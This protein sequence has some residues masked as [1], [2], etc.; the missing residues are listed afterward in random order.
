MPLKHINISFCRWLFCALL[1]FCAISEGQAAIDKREF[2]IQLK[3]GQ[4]CLDRHRYAD[5]YNIFHKLAG[6]YKSNL[7]TEDKLLSLEAIYGCIE[8]SID[9]VN[10][11]DA[12][13]YLMLAEEIRESENISD[14]RLHLFY[15]DLYIVYGA[16]SNKRSVFKYAY[17]HGKGAFD[18]F[19]E[20]GDWTRAEKAFGNLINIWYMLEK[21]PEQNK[22]LS[23]AKETFEKKVPDR[24]QKLNKLYFLEARQMEL[25]NNPKAASA[26]YDTIL[27]VIPDVPDNAILRAHMRC[28]AAIAR[29]NSGRTAEAMVALDSAI[30]ATIRW[31]IPNLQELAL[32][33]YSLILK[34]LGDS[35]KAADYMSRALE[36]K[37]SIRSFAVADDLFGLENMHQQKELRKEVYTARY[38][39]SVTMWILLFLGLVVVTV[40]IFLVILRRNN[41]KL[42]ERA[43]L[44]R[45]LLRERN[46]VAQ[47]KAAI[48][49]AQRYD[50]SN[51]KDEDKEHIA[52]DIRKVLESPAVFSSDFSLSTLS[53]MVGRTPK[54]VSQVVNEVFSTNFP[55]LVNKIRIYE[56]CRR[57]DSPDYSNWSVEGIAESVGYSQR[58]TFSSNFKKFTGMGIRE[59][60]RLSEQEKKD[61]IGGRDA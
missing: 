61:T 38:R 4:E 19:I 52:A 8:S 47:E 31:D 60:R 56:A 27:S 33:N 34:D 36:L 55:T 9:K 22:I 5:A 10:Y 51:P 16:H 14:G 21:T 1:L 57:I 12:V 41:L 59:Y 2:N 37:D 50:G 11:A 13:N 6:Q 25:Q 29:Y 54:A 39:H 20:T 17:E 48:A 42:R 15:C 26:Y 49:K 46:E 45:Q 7:S 30:E 40:V 58:N 3:K 35:V 18:F 23:D 44:L 53:E 28:Y 43:A 32:V 24:W